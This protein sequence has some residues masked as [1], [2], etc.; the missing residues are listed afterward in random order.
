MDPARI[1]G[2]QDRPKRPSIR[3]GRNNDNPTEYAIRRA[4]GVR[5]ADQSPKR[6]RGVLVST[7]GLYE[8]AGSL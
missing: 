3:D 5:G 6:Q 4:P 2:A 8:Y 1:L 7:R